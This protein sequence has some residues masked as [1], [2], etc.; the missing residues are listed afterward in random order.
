MSASIRHVS[1]GDLDS[2]DSMNFIGVL[3]IIAVLGFAVSAVQFV[4]IGVSALLSLSLYAD[5]GRSSYTP[6][7]SARLT[8]SPSLFLQLFLPP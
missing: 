4:R 8:S 7:S 6:F 1:T 3:A 2:R 5:P